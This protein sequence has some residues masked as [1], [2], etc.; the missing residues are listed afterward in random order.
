MALDGIVIS[1]L[2]YDL[3]RT[4]KG[5]RISKIA[6]PETDELLFTLKGPGGQTRLSISASASLPLMYLTDKNKPSPPSAPG[7]CM[8]RRKHIGTGRITAISQPG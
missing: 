5:A 8:H 1:N 4:V 2:I 3:D 7:F 6:Q